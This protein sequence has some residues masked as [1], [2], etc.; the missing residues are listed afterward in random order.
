MLDGG[1]L[2][3]K[4][5]LQSALANAGV[6]LPLA[7]GFEHGVGIDRPKPGQLGR[8]EIVGETRCRAGG[9]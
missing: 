9:D 4:P 6:P 7:T 8:K 3:I 1:I 5:E 2:R